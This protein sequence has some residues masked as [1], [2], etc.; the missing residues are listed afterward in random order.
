MSAAT[1]M[2]T[3]RRCKTI[4]S[5]LST[6]SPLFYAKMWMFPNSRA[7]IITIAKKRKKKGKISVN[8]RRICH[9]WWR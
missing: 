8:R 1:K 9:P 5:H 4:H 2:M 7:A 3:V 6:P